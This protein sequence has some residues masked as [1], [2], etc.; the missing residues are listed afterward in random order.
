MEEMNTTRA[1][2]TGA[3]THRMRARPVS[4][5][6]VMAMPPSSMMGA[7]MPRVCMDWMKLCTL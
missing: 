7:R 3:I 4:M 1:I 5:V 6:N 2:I